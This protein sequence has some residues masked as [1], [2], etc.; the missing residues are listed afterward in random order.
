MSIPP[1][2]S[3]PLWGPLPAE[4]AGGAAG[5]LGKSCTAQSRDEGWRELMAPASGG[6]AILSGVIHT[7]DQ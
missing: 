1:D 5:T 6:W 3:S 2:H 4:V 7:Y